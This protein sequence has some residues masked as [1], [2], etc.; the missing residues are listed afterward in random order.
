[1]ILSGLTGIYEWRAPKVEIV[2]LHES[3]PRTSWKNPNNYRIITDTSDAYVP[4]CLLSMNDTCINMVES[5]MNP[6]QLKDT[7]DDIPDNI[8]LSDKEILDRATENGTKPLFIATDGG[9]WSGV[10]HSCYSHCS[11]TVRDG[12][13]R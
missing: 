2:L 7:N 13:R 8:I 9:F 4:S 10:S 1:M 5:L 6:L 11:A 12:G 3:V